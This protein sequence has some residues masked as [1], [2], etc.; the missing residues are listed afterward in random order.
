MRG[1]RPVGR[2]KVRR[3]TGIRKGET[4]PGAG[5]IFFHHSDVARRSG[6]GGGRGG[7]K[8]EPPR[9]HREPGGEEGRGVWRGEGGGGK[10]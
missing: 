6:V 2:K 1:E 4:H 10:V 9:G 5:K 3:G 8:A 7:E